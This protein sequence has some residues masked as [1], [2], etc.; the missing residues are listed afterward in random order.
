MV[1]RTWFAAAAL[2]FSSSALGMAADKEQPAPDSKSARPDKRALEKEFA[3]T[4]SGATLVGRFTVDGKTDAGKPG[5][6]RYEIES[7]EKVEGHRWV[8]TSRIKYGKHDVK[9]PIPLE[10]F[11]AGDTPVITLTHVLVPGLGTF[12]SRVMVYGDR[13]AGTWQH[14]KAGGHLWGRIE[15]GAAPAPKATDA[16]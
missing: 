6:D 2:V 15:R 7:A 1:Y 12:T 16:K 3:Q 13:Y 4:L 5:S 9:L 11:W 14:D 10:V 8:I